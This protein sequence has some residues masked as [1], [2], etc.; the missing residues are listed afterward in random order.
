MDELARIRHGHIS[1][2]QLKPHL[3]REMWEGYFK[4]A[5]VRNPFDR[6]V[7]T[8]CYLLRQEPKFRRKPTALMK[9]AVANSRFRKRILVCPQSELLMSESGGVNLNYVGRFEQLDESCSDIFERLGLPA[10]SL[11]RRNASD[12]E[13]WPGYYDDALR[14]SVAALY[15][16]DLQNFGYTFDSDPSD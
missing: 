13:A 16:D 7:S 3:P 5:V 12:H 6:F 11:E 4:F 9:L 14:Q 1:V 10:T 2:R 8:C 15:R